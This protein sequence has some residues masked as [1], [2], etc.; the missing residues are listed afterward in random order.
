MS[1]TSPATTE[2]LGPTGA[3]L[4]DL[5]SPYLAHKPTGLLHL[6]RFI[7]KIRK[8]LAGG[9]PKSYQRNFCRGFDGFL[10]AHLGIDS[11][12]VIELVRECGDDCAL[13]DQRLLALLPADVNAAKWNREVVQKGMHGMGRE[14]LEEVKAEMGIADRSDLVC[15][16]D[17]IEYDEGRI[18]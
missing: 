13:L 6:P 1:E 15:F 11:K 2:Q 8:H 7:A 17:L 3:I 16:A 12:Q 9:L 14:R 10:C 5:P 4:R 18:V